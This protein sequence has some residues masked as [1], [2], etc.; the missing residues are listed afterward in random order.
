MPKKKP[1]QLPQVSGASPRSFDDQ[2]DAQSFGGSTRR[3]LWDPA[4]L[5]KG[6]IG[7]YSEFASTCL[8]ASVSREEAQSLSET[9]DSQLGSRAAVF[10]ATNEQLGGEWEVQSPDDIIRDVRRAVQERK[11]W[12]EE[13][14]DAALERRR[15][16]ERQDRVDRGYHIILP[17]NRV[18]AMEDQLSRRVRAQLLDEEE[19]PEPPPVAP[20]KKS[21]QEESLAKIGRRKVRNPWYQPAKTWYCKDLAKDMGE[22]RGGGFPYDSHILHKTDGAAGGSEEP[23]NGDGSIRAL[24]RREKETLQ[25]VDAYRIYMRDTMKGARLPH[26]L[27]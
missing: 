8:P 26:F 6:S 5:P 3:V 11:P 27:Q 24:T 20:P 21:S 10:E 1:V 17:D 4:T 15:Q 23:D 19:G 22:S 14:D 12:R 9:L 16:I 7:D 13:F 18:R 2:G 25:I